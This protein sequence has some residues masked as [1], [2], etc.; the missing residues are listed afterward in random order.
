MTPIALASS[1][2]IRAELLRRANVP[3]EVVK[4]PID[5]DTIKASLLAEGVPHRDVADA[6]AEAKARKASA[7]YPEKLVIGCDQVLS[8]DGALLSKPMSEDDA[9]KQIAALSGS[10]HTLLSAAV[11]Y[12][13]GEPLWRF[14]GVVKLTMRDI[15]EAYLADYVSRNWPEIS[16][17]VGSYQLEGEGV[18]L[19]SRIQGDHFHVLGLPLIELLSWLSLRGTVPG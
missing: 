12:Q 7:L 18:R 15:G 16:Y 8:F 13:S 4:A 10:T 3:F 19:F 9:K 11:V 6:L 5:E 14:I 1:S 2:T 17:C